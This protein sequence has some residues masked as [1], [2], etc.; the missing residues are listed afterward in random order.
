[1]K[2]NQAITRIA[3]YDPLT[4]LPNR[5]LFKILAEI[6]FAQARREGW[7]AY[8]LLID[9]DGFKIINDTYGHESGDEVLQQI[10]RRLRVAL[11]YPETDETLSSLKKLKRSEG[12]FRAEDLIARHG[13]DEFLGMLIHV[14]AVADVKSIAQRVV[15]TLQKPIQLP[16]NQVAVGASIGIAVFPD[17][18]ANLEELIMNAD[19]AMYEVKRSGKGT[20]RLYHPPLN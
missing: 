14:K 15:D 17:D 19:R 11:P 16:A 20:Y 4:Q 13:G 6:A 9:L 2:A 5:R 10:G 7:K 12:L 18:G 8:L 3:M 1:M